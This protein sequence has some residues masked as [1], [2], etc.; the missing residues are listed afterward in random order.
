MSRLTGYKLVQ[1]VAAFLCLIVPLMYFDRLGAS[2]FGGGS[3]TG[4]LLRI[5]D[6][7]I[8]MF[9]VALLVGI[10]FPRIA[11]LVG[12]SA[13]LSCLP[14]YVFLIAPGRVGLWLG[15]GEDSV[16]L[17]PA[18]MWNKW[19]LFGLMTVFI[20]MLV[21]IRHICWGTKTSVARNKSAAEPQNL[22]ISWYGGGFRLSPHSNP[23]RI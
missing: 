17:Q 1:A 5:G 23:G 9:V 15:G 2:E 11:A 18:V 21:C 7:A 13:C 16:P 4:P 19:A 10:K 3:L 6:F 20:Y 14:L 22:N 8:P 12:I